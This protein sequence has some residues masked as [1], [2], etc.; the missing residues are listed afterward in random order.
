[1][2]KQK[3]LSREEVTLILWLSVMYLYGKVER[4]QMQQGIFR[5]QCGGWYES[6]FYL[7]SFIRVVITVKGKAFQTTLGFKYLWEWRWKGC[8]CNTESCRSSG[9]GCSYDTWA[10]ATDTFRACFA[11][12]LLPSFALWGCKMHIVSPAFCVC[13]IKIALWRVLCLSSTREWRTGYSLGSFIL[14]V[15][16]SAVSIYIN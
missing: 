12:G 14:C 2:T 15:H 7:I 8:K 11:L 9:K 1:M 10:V 4:S 5:S 6:W 16:H 3:T 13:Y